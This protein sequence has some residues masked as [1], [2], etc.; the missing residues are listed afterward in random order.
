MQKAET[1]IIAL[2]NVKQSD[3]LKYTDIV[4]KI[5]NRVLGFLE[6]VAHE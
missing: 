3:V 2:G 5:G 6:G 1:L 4:E